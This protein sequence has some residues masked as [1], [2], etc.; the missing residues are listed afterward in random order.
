MLYNMENKNHQHGRM[1][2][3]D[4]IRFERVLPGS[5]EAVWAYL[6]ESEKRGKWLAYA[7][8][9]FT[10]GAGRYCACEFLGSP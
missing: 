5:A 10:G 6:T 9:Y 7:S 8:G 1:T 4:T 2:E 3:A